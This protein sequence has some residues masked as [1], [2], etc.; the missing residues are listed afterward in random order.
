MSSGIGR[1][2]GVGSSASPIA[3]TE[4]AASS[5]P[6][7]VTTSSLSVVEWAT[8]RNPQKSFL[9]DRNPA[10]K[11]HLDTINKVL[12]D[13][14][15]PSVNDVTGLVINEDLKKE[16]CALFHEQPLS[17]KNIL[18]KIVAELCTSLSEKKSYKRE[19]EE[20]IPEPS[21]TEIR[22]LFSRAGRPMPAIELMGHAKLYGKLLRDNPRA[23]KSRAFSDINL[24]KEAQ[25]LSRQRVSHQDGD[26][27]D[28][29]FPKLSR[30]GHTLPRLVFRCKRLPED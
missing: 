26:I 11:S 2:G 23:P 15:F 7:T 1:T 3:P 18:S 13:N 5:A 20:K 21:G 4:P 27:L 28:L 8:E 30:M 25:P 16:L 22:D 9:D 17:T 12:V 10:L 14:S 6:A 29:V 24:R 19:T